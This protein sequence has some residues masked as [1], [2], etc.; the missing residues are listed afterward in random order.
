MSTSSAIYLLITATKPTA[1]SRVTDCRSPFHGS[2]ISR[3]KAGMPITCIAIC[4]YREFCP[5]EFRLDRRH[6]V[7][8]DKFTYKKVETNWILGYTDIASASYEI[9]IFKNT[10]S[11]TVVRIIRH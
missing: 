6:Y 4:T 7:S 5:T 11:V 1:K 3:P 9:I 8:I 2:E 10:N